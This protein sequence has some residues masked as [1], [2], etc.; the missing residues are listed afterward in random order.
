MGEN[1]FEPAP[2]PEIYWQRELTPNGRKVNDALDKH[3]EAKARRDLHASGPSEHARYLHEASW[4][5]MD[6]DKR[7]WRAERQQTGK[8][9]TPQERGERELA[10][11]GKDAKEFEAG[12]QSG[13]LGEAIKTTDPGFWQIDLDSKVESLRE[14]GKSD[15]GYHFRIAVTDNHTFERDGAW[16][17]AFATEEAAVNASRG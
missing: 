2:K 9:V 10:A 7:E 3:E 15:N 14:L 12:C 6:R 4:R 17:R 16:S 13:P 11:S 1:Y 8:L 5:L